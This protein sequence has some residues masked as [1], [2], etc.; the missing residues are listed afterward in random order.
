ML[1]AVGITGKRERKGIYF[2]PVLTTSEEE[3]MSGHTILTWK[4]VI[5]VYV[6]STCV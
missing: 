1:Y 2:A 4:H 6:K 5:D 3:G